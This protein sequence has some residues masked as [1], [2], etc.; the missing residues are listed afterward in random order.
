MCDLN[1]DASTVADKLLNN[2]YLRLDSTYTRRQEGS[3]KEYM[4]VPKYYKNEKDVESENKVF[5]PLPNRLEDP[6]VVSKRGN[7]NEGTYSMESMNLAGNIKVC[8]KSTVKEC[9][10]YEYQPFNNLSK[11]KSQSVYFDA[12]V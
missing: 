7:N 10:N 2:N 8:N 6:F 5:W 4:Y 11:R 9:R 3:Y 1:W 12:N